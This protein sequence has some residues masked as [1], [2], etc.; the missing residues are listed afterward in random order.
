MAGVTN[1]DELSE[2][3]FA[4]V[5]LSN[6]VLSADRV[7]PGEDQAVT[8]VLERLAA[9]L[10]LAVEF[11]ARGSEALAVQAVR[12]VPLV[13]LFRLGVSLIG[14]LRKL[15][16]ALLKETPFAKL[17]REFH[18]FETEEADVL[19]AVTRL[20][21]LFPRA[22]ETP[23]A[24]GE[25]PF[26][27]LAD[28]ALVASALERAGAVVALLH[29]LGVRP[30]AIAE[31]DD[32]AAVD[33]GE[34]ARTVLVAR[35]LGDQGPLHPLTAATIQKFEKRFKDR[36]QARGAVRDVLPA[37]PGTASAAVLDRWADSLVPLEPV[38]Q[39]KTKRR[40]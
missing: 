27:Q 18:L 19:A 32:P 34:L 31:L 24:A 13:R 30:E 33:A 10:D 11:L 5:A 20:R 7:V 15:G 25:R 17:P 39:A 38:L 21:P 14:K 6:R 22:L 8:A 23:P 3:R 4:L 2:L 12:T 16:V 36:T 1:A 9:T 29:G 28:I 40:R 35:L 26:A 37:A